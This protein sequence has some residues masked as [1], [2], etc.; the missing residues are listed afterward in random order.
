MTVRRLGMLLG[1]ATLVATGSYVFV[2]L[3]R[4][5]WNRALISAALFLAAE[6]AVVGWRIADR[7]DALD[8][9]VDDLAAHRQALVTRR[10]EETAPDARQ[11]FAW[12]SRPDRLSVF[13]PA[14]MGA[15]LL[16]SGLAWVVERV[17][18]STVRPAA[19]RHLAS[20]LGTFALPSRGF[21]GTPEDPLDVLR[22]PGR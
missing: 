7:L 21:L 2:Y 1:A 3:Y 4:W 6:V 11:P 14:L 20:Q 10:L 19:E 9:R 5:E 12:L 16:L 15:G 13:V 17:A 18:R 8:R 22:R